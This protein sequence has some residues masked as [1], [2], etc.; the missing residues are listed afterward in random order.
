MLAT[1]E[2]IG[3]MTR[4]EK[5]R[6]L[7]WLQTSLAAD[8]V[9]AEPSPPAWHEEVLAERRRRVEAGE[10]AFEPWETVEERLRREDP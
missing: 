5:L 1:R 8:G 2:E 10:E 7:E 4:E 3:R 6:A 9:V